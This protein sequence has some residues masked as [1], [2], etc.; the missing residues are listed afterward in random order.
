MT[1][2]F[3]YCPSDYPFEE[4]FNNYSVSENTQNKLNELDILVLP[5]P[6]K[7]SK[8]YF[9]QEAV[10]FVKY[11]NS[12]NDDVQ[13]DILADI[14]KVEVRALHSFD[15]WMPIIWIANAIVFPIV[16][17]LVTNYIY[18]RMKGRENE[19]CT[20]KITF[21]IKDGKKTKELNYDGDA[22][23]FKETFEKIDIS[24]L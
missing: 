7:N 6:Y 5:H 18:D 11:C 21:I 10:G 16:I 24:K 4:Y 2:G 13:I 19:D 9:A 8:Y 20:V 1:H 17:G 3:S 12:L 23:T 14:D 15:I 22:K